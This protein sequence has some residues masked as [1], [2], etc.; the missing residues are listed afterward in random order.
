MPR[1]PTHRDRLPP[2]TRSPDTSPL[3]SPARSLGRYLPLT[4]PI[5]LTPRRRSP[6]S[7][8]PSCAIVAAPSGGNRRPRPSDSS[9]P[10]NFIF[11]A[12]TPSHGLG[13]SFGLCRSSPAD[14]TQ[15]AQPSPSETIRPVP[16][17]LGFGPERATRFARRFSPAPAPSPA[18]PCSWPNAPFRG[19]TPAPSAQPTRATQTFARPAQLADPAPPC[20]RSTLFRPPGPV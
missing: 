13:P 9:P 5:S 17:R 4:V 7:P 10:P 2:L 1:L 6:P 3:T 12:H 8:A 19:P 15:P 16:P 14:S 20:S 11:S 18:R